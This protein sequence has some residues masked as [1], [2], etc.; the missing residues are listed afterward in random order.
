MSALLGKLIPKKKIRAV[1]I[2]PPLNM[3]HNIHVTMNRETGRLEG[4]PEDWSKSIN[5]ESSSNQLGN[6][7][8][9]LKT[10]SVK[11]CPE[12]KIQELSKSSVPDA[13]AEN[14]EE[15]VKQCSRIS[16]IHDVN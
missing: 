8:V 6:T 4:L 16:T 15:I 7:G 1:D 13:K 12:D 3:E 14:E 2:G 10:G 5:A 11:R 9:V